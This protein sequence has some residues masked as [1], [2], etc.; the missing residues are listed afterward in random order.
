MNKFSIIIP[1][2]WRSACLHEA[3]PKYNDCRDIGEIII[4]D[5]DPSKSFDLSAYSKVKVYT[6]GENIFVNP[7]WNWGVELSKY[8]TILANDD[9]EI[10]DVNVITKLILESDYDIIGL[11]MKKSDDKARLIP[12][13]SFPSN[14]YGCFMYVKEY[15]AI[16]NDLKM[17]YG[18]YILFNAAKKRGCFADCGIHTSPSQTINSDPHYFRYNIGTQDRVMYERLVRDGTIASIYS[19]RGM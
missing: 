3:I 2:M 17:W 8:R 10:A 11:L 15:V 4:I 7:A 12:V 9:V 14:S 16:P 6:K 18:D 5:N 19:K 1:T 13:K